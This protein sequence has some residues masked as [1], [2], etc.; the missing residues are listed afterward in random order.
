MKKKIKTLFKIKYVL[1]VL[2]IIL[3]GSIV[4][5]YARGGN[6]STYKN[7][8]VSIFSPV[9]NAV[10]GIRNAINNSAE[11]K[12]SK[13][14][15]KAEN[16][17][18]RT[19]NEKLKSIIEKYQ[20][21]IYE[22]QELKSLLD[23]SGE[24]SAYGT[25]AANVIGKNTGNWIYEF[26]IDKGSDDGI[27]MYMNV[28]AD[29]GLAGLVTDVGKNYSVVTSILADDM[30]VAGISS[31]TRDS[32]IVSGDLELLEEGRI[33]IMYVHGDADI[34][35]YDR[36]VTSTTSNRYLPHI[37]IGYAHDITMDNNEL[38][39]SGYLVPAVDFQ[40]LEYVMVIKHVKG[41][42]KE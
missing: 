4:L 30:N 15:L 40:H 9:R 31:T 7:G 3:L 38:T 2:T 36:I 23:L 41:K 6:L 17:E 22:L 10:A 14:E 37:L 25:V 33:R 8:I 16:K 26:T 5:T 1:L 28:V 42:N 39:K 20:T 35:D 18:L 21:D 12:K 24:Y 13:E 11:E 34:K 19:E 32:C 29:G 27:E